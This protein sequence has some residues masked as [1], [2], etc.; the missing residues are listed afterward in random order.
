MVDLHNACRQTNVS[1][2]LKVC[3]GLWCGSAYNSES[4]RG[5]IIKKTFLHDPKLSW[6]SLLVFYCSFLLVTK[7][8]PIFL[9]KLNYFMLQNLR[10]QWRPSDSRY[11]CQ[12]MLNV[13]S[14]FLLLLSLRLKALFLSVQTTII[15]NKSGLGLISAPLFRAD[16]SYFPIKVFHKA[17]QTCNIHWCFHC[18][19]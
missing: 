3:F 2:I 13:K 16:G 6:G 8:T 12:G 9:P 11:S 17:W 1:L 15:S 14:I 4:K 10:I 5:S 19:S 7:S 18:P